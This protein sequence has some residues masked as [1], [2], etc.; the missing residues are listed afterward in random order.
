MV[1]WLVLVLDLSALRFDSVA[2][3]GAS[4]RK[5]GTGV[6]ILG[7]IGYTAIVRFPQ[8][9]HI[10]KTPFSSRGAADRG[11]FV[12]SRGNLSGNESRPPVVTAFTALT[13]VAKQQT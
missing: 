13:G 1:S 12:S 6:A 11:A 4:S 10:D 8:R 3:E 2:E 9:R 7:G 5:S